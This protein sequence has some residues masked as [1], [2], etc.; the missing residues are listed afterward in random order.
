MYA[1]SQKME[2]KHDLFGE[3]DELTDMETTEYELFDLDCL[4]FEV[5]PTVEYDEIDVDQST[6]VLA[7]TAE[8]EELRLDR[9]WGAAFC[10][11]IVPG[12]GQVLQGD[13]FRGFLFF[14]LAFCTCSMLGLVNLVSAI[15]V[16]RR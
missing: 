6:E 10:S 12:S 9:H 8:Y 3:E 13:L 1:E 14:G 11:L 15:D 5:A 7:L 4:I 2:W 16:L